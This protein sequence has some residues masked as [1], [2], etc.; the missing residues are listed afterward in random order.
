[1]NDVELVVV[2]TFH[3]KMEAQIAQ[4]ALDAENIESIV[5]ADDAWYTAESL[6]EWL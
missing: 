5:T 6:D 3:N 1:M 4:G 2:R